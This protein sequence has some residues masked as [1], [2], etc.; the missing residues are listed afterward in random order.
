[1]LNFPIFQQ[2]YWSFLYCSTFCYRSFNFFK[3]KVFAL[4]LFASFLYR[5]CTLIYGFFSVLLF[6]QL[7]RQLLLFFNPL[8]MRKSNK[9]CYRDNYNGIKERRKEV[10]PKMKQRTKRAITLYGATKKIQYYFHDIE[11]INKL[12]GETNYILG[13]PI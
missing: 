2:Q 10:L 12:I 13:A 4:N 6:I 11:W 9:Y 7:L 1:M 8:R 3:R 5:F